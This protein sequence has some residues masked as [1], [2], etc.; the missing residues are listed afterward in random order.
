MIA[1]VE[2]EM[3]VHKDLFT[4]RSPWRE[5]Y[6]SIGRGSPA[7]DWQFKPHVRRWRWTTMTHPLY[8]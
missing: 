7:F 6:V 2:L 5:F 3:C 8:R 4:W 1:R